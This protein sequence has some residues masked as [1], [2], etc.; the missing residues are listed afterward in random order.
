MSKT[1]VL[2]GQHSCKHLK[3]LKGIETLA[4][5]ANGVRDFWLQT[6]KTPERD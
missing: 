1:K 3:P 4:D 6:S 5:T 2:E